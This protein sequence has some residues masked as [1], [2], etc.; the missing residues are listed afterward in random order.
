MRGTARLRLRVP[1]RSYPQAGTRLRS[2]KVEPTPLDPTRRHSG[3]L[4]IHHCGQTRG[5][6]VG[7]VLGEINTARSLLPPTTLH[8]SQ[9]E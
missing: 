9:S 6:D 4:F 5:L 8:H 3:T 2:G 1:R 7:V